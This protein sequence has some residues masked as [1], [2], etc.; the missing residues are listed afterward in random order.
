MVVSDSQP[1]MTDEG[2]HMMLDKERQSLECFAPGVD[3]YL[4]GIPLQQLESGEVDLAGIIRKYRMASFLVPRHLGG[5]GLSAVE[6]ARVQRAIGARSPSLAIMLTM[7][8]FTCGFLAVSRLYESVGEKLL[9][10]IADHQLLLAS[11]FAEGRSGAGVFESTLYAVK[12]SGGYVLN[13]SK[14]PCSLSR[15]LDVLTA[16]V[17]VR[18]ADGQVET[19]L[20]MIPRGAPGLSQKLFWNSPILY[21]AENHEVVFKD[22]FVPSEHIVVSEPHDCAAQAHMRSLERLG[23]SWFQVFVAASY[24]GMASN[25]AERVIAR[26]HTSV[27]DVAELGVELEGAMLSVEGAAHLLDAATSW[28]DDLLGQARMARFSVQ[29]AIQ[30]AGFLA[31]EL[32]GGMAFIGSW[33]VG[34]LSSTLNCLAY[35][36]A[37]RRLADP[38]MAA[39]LRL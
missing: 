1:Q 8:G 36:P 25:L 27:H 13:G 2:T 32:L 29:K 23:Q 19:G 39:V 5:Q 24:L 21:A 38:M 18:Y 31:T 16:G 20:A 26:K 37:N 7:H 34:Y 3:A 11:G 9:R 12:T 30:R 6:A 14:K 10:T 4:A 33:D 22:V 17:A 28:T 15:S 35:H